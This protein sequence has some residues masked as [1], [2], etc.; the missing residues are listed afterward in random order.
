VFGFLAPILVLVFSIGAARA[1]WAQSELYREFGQGFYLPLLSLAIL[2][3]G[4]LAIVVLPYAVGWIPAV[5]V[6]TVCFAPA[7]LI[8]RRYANIFDRSGTSRTANALKSANTAIAVSMA[9]LLYL[10]AYLVFWVAVATL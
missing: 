9:C 2:P 1:V 5:V 3:L 10:G 4:A 8:F 7:L 6:A